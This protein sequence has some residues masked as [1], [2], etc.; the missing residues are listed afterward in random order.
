M[1]V[2]PTR[3]SPRPRPRG[4]A[5]LFCLPSARQMW[6]PSAS[7][8]RSLRPSGLVGSP[9]D[10]EMKRIGVVATLFC[11]LLGLAAFSCGDPCADLQLK[12]EECCD[13]QN[14]DDKAKAKECRESVATSGVAEED[15][16]ACAALY[17]SFKC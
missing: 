5:L 16:A 11:M 10:V 13:T 8:R 9:K 14:K 2:S 4:S 17:D 7:P 1:L 6:C 3:S 15:V 12:Q